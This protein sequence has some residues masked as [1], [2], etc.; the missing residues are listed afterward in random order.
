MTDTDLHTSEPFGTAHGGRAFVQ[1]HVPGGDKRSLILI[2]G[3]EVGGEIALS[4]TVAADFARRILTLT[5]AA[6]PSW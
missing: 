4:L 2:T 3:D 6:E 5:D 1:I